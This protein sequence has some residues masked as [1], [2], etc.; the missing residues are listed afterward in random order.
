MRLEN[1][2]LSQG[3]ALSAFAQIGVM[4]LSMAVVGVVAGP[5]ASLPAWF[6]VKNVSA[7]IVES[8]G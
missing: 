3:Q 1:D 6:T 2:A 4:V 7:W 8:V 5:V